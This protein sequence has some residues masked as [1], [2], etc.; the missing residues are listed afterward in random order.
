MGMA[1]ETNRNIIDWIRAAAYAPSPILPLYMQQVVQLYKNNIQI[2]ISSL[3]NT[4]IF[5]WWIWVYVLYI[6]G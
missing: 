3:K 1:K 5:Y 4:D 6:V 2:L